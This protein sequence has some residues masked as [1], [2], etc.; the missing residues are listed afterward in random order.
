MKV[1]TIINSHGDTDCVLD[2]IDSVLKFVG[3]EAILIVDGGNWDNWGKNLVAPIYKLEGFYHGCNRAPYRNVA[4]GIKQAWSMWGNK[5]D[6]FC[7]IEYDCLFGSSEFKNYLKVADEK[8]IWCLGNDYRMGKFNF[9]LIEQ[10]LRCK[11]G[12]SSYLLGC[13]VFYKNV[14]VEKLVESNFFEKFL[15]MTNEF[16]G[17]FFP[18]YEQQGGY[19]LSEHLYPTLAGKFGGKIGELA[20][21]DESSMSW[22]GEF[23]KFPLRYRP[24][25]CQING[26]NID[27]FKEASICHPV[28]DFSNPIREYYRKKRQAM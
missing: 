8:G 17:G 1:A 10:M 3:P 21:W 19:D 14:F 25:L 24:D 5:V 9:P 2:T 12:V 22:R 27:L 16:S 28:K 20:C 26:E 4:L 7:Y 15:Y 11:L 6:W 23:K 13:C 18:H